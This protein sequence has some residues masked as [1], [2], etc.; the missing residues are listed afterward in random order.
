MERQILHQRFEFAEI[1]AFKNYSK[2]TKKRNPFSFDID[3][4]IESPDEDEFHRNLY[5]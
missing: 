2:L 5:F 3:E 1:Q 4:V